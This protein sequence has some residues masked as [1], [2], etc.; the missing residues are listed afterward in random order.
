MTGTARGRC[1]WGRPALHRAGCRWPL[2]PQVGARPPLCWPFRLSAPGHGH[3]RTWGAGESLRV[4]YTASTRGASVLRH[5]VASRWGVDETDTRVAGRPRAEHERRSGRAPAPLAY[6]T[7]T[8][9]A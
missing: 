7:S 8:G 5:G 9:L 6:V 1:R 2:K 4:E 3:S